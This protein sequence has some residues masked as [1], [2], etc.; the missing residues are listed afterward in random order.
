MNQASGMEKSWT[1]VCSMPGERAVHDDR[2][3]RRDERGEDG[4]RA[5]DGD[6]R[7]ELDSVES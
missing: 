4:R 5:R 6:H 1:W 2:L 7:Q 3:D